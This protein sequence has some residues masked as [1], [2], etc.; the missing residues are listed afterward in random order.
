[1]AWVIAQLN[2][3]GL[4]S[5]RIPNLSPSYALSSPVPSPAALRLAL[6]DTAIRLTGSFKIGEQIFELVKCAPLEIEPPH[7]VS[8]VKVFIKRLKPSK[9]SGKGCEESFGVREYCHFS[10]PMKVY[11]QLVEQEDMVA[12]LFRKL[13][14]LG[15]TDSILSC[16]A[17]IQKEAPDSAFTCKL[18][19]TIRP[20][21]SNFLKRPVVTLNE[22]D[23]AANFS[24][25][26]PYSQEKRGPTF[27]S[28]TYLLPLIEVRRGMNYIFYEKVPFSL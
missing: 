26:N 6:V 3:A 17:T 5:Y 27:I 21:M 23:K 19:S 12:D 7:N 1:M 18:I 16:L 11:L 28:Q 2:F 10:D 24:Q 14:R 8:I 9:S 13:R 22:I 20:D 4:F 15:T 25:V